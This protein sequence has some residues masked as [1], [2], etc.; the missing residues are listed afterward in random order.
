LAALGVVS[1]TSTSGYCVAKAVKVK[2][3]VIWGAPKSDDDTS[4]AEAFIDW[5]SS[6]GFSSGN[7]KSDISISNAKPCFVSSKPPVGSLCEFWNELTS[8]QYCTIRVPVNGI[9]DVHVN[10]KQAEEGVVGPIVSIFSVGFMYYGKLDFST[11]ALLAP[12]GLASFGSDSSTFKPRIPKEKVK[13]I[14]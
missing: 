6:S 7:K 12:V 10:W 14:L 3:I 2:K 8:V 1:V 5:H 4:Y 9:V 13:P 11:T